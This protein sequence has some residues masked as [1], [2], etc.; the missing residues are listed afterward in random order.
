MRSTFFCLK[1]KSGM[2][3]FSELDAKTLHGIRHGYSELEDQGFWAIALY[4]K[5]CDIPVYTK[6]KHLVKEQKA[7]FRRHNK[8][9]EKSY[10]TNASEKSKTAL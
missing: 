3:K 8:K 4:C 2:N 5:R 6:L 10:G 1:C 9:K 7:A